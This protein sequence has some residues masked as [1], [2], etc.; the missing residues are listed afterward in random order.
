M[1]PST[2]GPA[3]ARFGYWTQFPRDYYLPKATRLERTI[4]WLFISGFVGN[5]A[6]LGW[7]SLKYGHARDYFFEITFISVDWLMLIVGGLMATAVFRRDVV[8]AMVG[9]GR[10]P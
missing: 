5:V 10:E 2:E 1:N 8:G 3:V 9:Y 6:A 4:R 7:F